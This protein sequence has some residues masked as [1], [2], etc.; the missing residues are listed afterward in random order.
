MR[1]VLRLISTVT[2]IVLLRTTMKQKRPKFIPLTRKRRRR[3]ILLPRQSMLPPRHE[4]PRMRRK[5]GCKNTLDTSIGTNIPTYAAQ[6]KTWILSMLPTS[7]FKTM[8][9]N[10]EEQPHVVVMATFSRA[11]NLLKRNGTTSNQCWT[12]HTPILVSILRRKEM[13]LV[14]LALKFSISFSRVISTTS[15]LNI[16]S[17][18]CS[19][20]Y[21]ETGIPDW[22]RRKIFSSTPCAARERSNM[23]HD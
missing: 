23:P 14:C 15:I 2:P 22:T 13:H 11:S 20:Y 21:L 4:W 17:F 1:K 8:R 9:E 5:S 10:C 7:S 12:T 19:R 18:T 3:P 6:S 16:R